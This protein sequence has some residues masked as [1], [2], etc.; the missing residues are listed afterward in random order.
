LSGETLEVPTPDLEVA[1]ESGQEGL[2]TF[3][4]STYAANDVDQPTDKELKFRTT[5]SLVGDVETVLPAQVTAEDVPY[6]EWH[7]EM[8]VAA[9]RGRLDYMRLAVQGGG[10]PSAEDGSGGGK[11]E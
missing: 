1:L 10:A 5:I 3:T 7:R 4:V 11:D 6:L 9:W 2:A 8:V